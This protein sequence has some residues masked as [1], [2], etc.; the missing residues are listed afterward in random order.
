MHVDSS[1]VVA[2]VTSLVNGIAGAGAPL[3]VCLSNAR[4]NRYRPLSGMGSSQW[5]TVETGDPGC[6]GSANAVAGARAT[7]ALRPIATANT[8][9]WRV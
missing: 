9:L 7:P 1:H 3:K 5:A 8:P 6:A 2:K 4:F